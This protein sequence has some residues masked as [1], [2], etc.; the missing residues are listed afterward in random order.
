MSIFTIKRIPLYFKHLSVAINLQMSTVIPLFMIF[1]FVTNTFVSLVV[2]EK[3]T[4][5]YM[6]L[7]GVIASFIFML[8][9][10]LRSREMTRFGF[11][12]FLF[13]VTLICLSLVNSVDVKNAV[14][15]AMSIWLY[16]LLLR[17]Y[18]ERMPVIM[19]L[20]AATCSFWV[21]MNFVHMLANP[22]MWLIEDQKEISGYM[23]G[24]N[25]NQMGCRM[26]LTLVINALCVRYSKVWLVNFV[27]LSIVIIASLSMVGS[28]TSLSMILVFLLFCVLPSAKFRKIMVASLFAVFVLFEVFVVFNGRGL[29]NN[30]LAVYI[31]EDLLHKDITFTYRTYMWYSALKVIMKSPLWGWGFVDLDWYVSNMSSFAKGPHNFV[32]SVFINGGLILFSLY[33]VICI[34]A[35]NGIKHYFSERRAQILLMGIVTLYFMSLMEMYPYP[36]MMLPLAFAYYYKYMC[37]GQNNNKLETINNIKV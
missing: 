23:L 35:Y 18:R 16:L 1:C 31:I 11:L 26:L 25:Y 27:L 19:M 33:V 22:A 4:I 20:F 15:V 14:Y 13:F 9:L 32:L 8:A 37:D 30:Q 5:S 28:M 12:H 7:A 29:E 21:Y 17:Y 6:V 3:Q 34:Y 24:G 10:M 2:L 36:F